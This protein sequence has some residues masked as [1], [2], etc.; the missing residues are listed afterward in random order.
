MTSRPCNLLH[1]LSKRSDLLAIYFAS[2]GSE[3]MGFSGDLPLMF[4]EES[5]MPPTL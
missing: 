2:L 1:I 3:F 5:R 4:L